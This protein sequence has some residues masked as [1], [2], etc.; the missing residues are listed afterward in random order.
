M[1]LTAKIHALQHLISQPAA[2]P[3]K[4]LTIIVKMK[5]VAEVKRSVG[6]VM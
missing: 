1:S 4:G 2:L 3:V 5:R 6:V